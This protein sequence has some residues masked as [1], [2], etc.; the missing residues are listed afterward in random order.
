MV[1]VV[2][3]AAGL[4]L[5]LGTPAHAAE[6]SGIDVSHHQG[7]INW[8][9]VSNSGKVF[10]FMKATEGI[11]FDDP[12]YAANR[13]DAG[14][15]GV[16]VG[17]YH[18]ARPEGSTDKKVRQ[19]ARAEARHFLRV[20]APAPGDLYPVLD[21]EQYGG[22]NPRRVKMWTRTWLSKVEKELD[23][24]PLIYTSPR[25]WEYYLNDTS[26]FG[27]KGYG[28]WIAH[29]T[30]NP[31]PDVPGNFWGGNGWSFW[32]YTSSGRVPGISGNVDLN[33][34]AS[35]AI[36]E[37]RI[38]IP[39]S[40]NNQP[41]IS[42]KAATGE[43]LTVS[44]GTWKGTKPMTFSYKWQRCD[45]SGTNCSAIN[46]ADAN[47]YEVKKWDYNDRLRAV[48]T[49]TNEAGNASSSTSVTDVVADGKA[50]SIP[51]VRSKSGA[52]SR[53]LKMT[54]RWNAS[55]DI[56]DSPLFDV[57]YREASK[58]GDFGARTRW[59]TQSAKR[60]S[61]MKGTPGH[62][63]CYSARARDEAGNRSGW[64]EERCVAI[65]LDDAQLDGG[66]KW[67]RD[68]G[69]RYFQRTVSTAT[70][71]GATLRI[72]GVD[73]RRFDLLAT[74]CPTC[75]RVEVRLGNKVLKQ[76]SLKANKRKDRVV[77]K[78][79]TFAEFERGTIYIEVLSNNKPV[80]IDGL[81]IW[82]G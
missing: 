5:G 44:N 71:R 32:Q 58:R 52:F 36:S 63:Y 80:R 42:G 30:E 54:L 9:K 15:A 12:K 34:G 23:V 57:R 18:F 55:D 70:K 1:A 29:Y 4:V 82:R 51:I 43:T 38:P 53:S 59:L 81:G 75:G 69:R 8:T 7:S 16:L 41:V 21:L 24:K 48:V 28:L 73:G 10:A 37:F 74:M 78:L 56:T 45:Q 35:G 31:Q 46:G 13:V 76:V 39:P 22:L 62:T 40:V 26:E 66:R 33:T 17:A 19:D 60:S 64:G 27:D 72:S 20:A 47:L 68:T 25:S 49:A 65:R 61:T 11:T 79:A 6:T 50:P 3:L 14:S 2:T 67:S 77:I